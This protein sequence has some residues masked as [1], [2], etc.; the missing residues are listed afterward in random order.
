MIRSIVLL[1]CA[2]AALVAQGVPDLSGVWI[3]RGSANLPDDL[4]YRPEALKLWQARKA[5]LSKDDP[6]AYCLPNG[7]VRV[8]SLPY[9]IVQTPQLVVLLSEGNTHSFRRFFL[10]GRAH[11]LDL[12]PNSWTGDSTGK[13]EGTTLVVDTIGF[14]DRSWLDDTGKPHSDQLHVIERY[15]RPDAGSLEVQYTLEDP[16]FL[17]RPYS[18]TRTFVPANREIQERFCTEQNHLVGK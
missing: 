2:A 18:F 7:V 9:K 1:A 13:W 6:A 8:T 14:N 5:N 11:N 10:D 15:R 3:V 4:P 17:T 16:K 12:E